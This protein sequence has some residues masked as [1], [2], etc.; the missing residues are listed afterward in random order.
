[1]F[2]ICLEENKLYDVAERLIKRQKSTN[3]AEDMQSFKSDVPRAWE[4]ASLPPDQSR[5]EH[6]T[7]FISVPSTISK[8][9]IS[10]RNTDKAG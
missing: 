7:V 5:E 9:A 3:K 1:M 10:K 6:M 2:Y 8:S 4:Y